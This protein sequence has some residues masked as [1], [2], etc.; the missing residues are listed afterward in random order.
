MSKRPEFINWIDEEYFH[1]TRATA[2]KFNEYLNDVAKVYKP[3]NKTQYK[4]TIT[5]DFGDD[6]VISERLKDYLVGKYKVGSKI[7]ERSLPRNCRKHGF[8]KGPGPALSKVTAP[9]LPPRRLMYY[10]GFPPLPKHPAPKPLP[11]RPTL[12]KSRV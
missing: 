11:K 10:T 1:G 9:Y 8:Y 5:E 6:G 4:I 7:Y 2:K 12:K 3:D